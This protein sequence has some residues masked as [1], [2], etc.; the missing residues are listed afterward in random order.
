M[1]CFSDTG[2]CTFLV[3]QQRYRM[4]YPGCTACTRIPVYIGGLVHL[5]SQYW[6]APYLN[7]F[8]DR[9]TVLRIQI[10]E[11]QQ[12]ICFQFFYTVCLGQYKYGTSTVT[13]QVPYNYLYCTRTAY[14]FA[15][16]GQNGSKMN[17]QTTITTP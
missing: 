1:P 16:T 11:L 3:M 8:S 14:E 7:R 5:Y 4:V 13:V 9:I 6:Y 10:R 15:N 2:I 17:P 12:I